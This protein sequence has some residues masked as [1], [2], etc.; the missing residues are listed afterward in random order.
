MPPE[1]STANILRIYLAIL[2]VYNDQG[3]VV[4]GESFKRVFQ[5]RFSIPM[6]RKEFLKTIAASGI[7]TGIGS[8]RNVSADEANVVLPQ[9]LVAVM[10]GDPVE[11]FRKG[12]ELFGG[13]KVFVKK[14][15]KIVVKPNIAWDKAPELAANTHP[16]LVAEIVRQAYE[17][18]AAEVQVFDHTCDEWRKSYK[19]SGIEEAARKAGAK[20]LQADQESDFVEVS[21]PKAKN[22]KTALIHKS[23]LECDAWFNVPVLKHHGGAQMTAAMKNL[24]GIVWDRQAFHHNNLNQCIA[25]ISGWEKGPILNIVDA[26]RVVKTHGPRGVSVGDVSEPKALF[27]SPDIVAVD[28]AA[29]KFFGQF[30]DLSVEKVAYLSMAEKMGIGT[31]AIDKLRVQKVKI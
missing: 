22:L 10:G 2:V 9:D 21:L 12:I 26:Y 11:M 29:A 16:E 30:A 5:E 20:I 25:D 18:G 7:A 23:L 28:T 8:L 24:M 3:K 27:I 13:M 6:D 31:T 17:A 4:L 14:G 15:Q 19:S 1:N